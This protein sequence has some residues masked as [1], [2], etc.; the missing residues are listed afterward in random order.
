MKRT[1]KRPPP[2]NALTRREP[3]SRDL[4]TGQGISAFVELS[5]NVGIHLERNPRTSAQ[6]GAGIVTVLDRAEG[7]TRVVADV[8]IVLGQEMDGAVGMVNLDHAVDR[9][10]GA[11]SKGAMQASG[12]V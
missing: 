7:L 5:R 9:E 12:P 11:P 10:T 4:F 3:C 6:P 2:G 1:T 8:M